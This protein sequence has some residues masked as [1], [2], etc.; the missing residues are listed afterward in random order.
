M[1]TVDRNRF[2]RLYLPI[3]M[4]NHLSVEQQTLYC[5]GA[6]VNEHELQE[7]D[8]HLSVCLAC[9][10][11]LFHAL[12]ENTGTLRR[13][14]LPARDESHCLDDATMTGYVRGQLDA[15]DREVVETHLSLCPRCA[16][17]VAS[18]QSFHEQM[19]R[20]DWTTLPPETLRERLRRLFH[21]RDF[22][23]WPTFRQVHT[24]WEH[25]TLTGR[26]ITALVVG[27]VLGW[28]LGNRATILN[29]VSD[30]ILRLLG[31]LATPLIF[32][33]IIHAFLKANVNAATARKL[34]VLLLTNT[35]VAIG[36]GLI[37]VNVFKP[38]R[39]VTAEGANQIADVAS[40]RSLAHKMPVSILAAVAE[41]NIVYVILAAVGIGIALRSVRTEQQRAGRSNFKSV[42]DLAE[43]TLLT[44]TKMIQW[45]IALVPF[46][47]CAI[48]AN[49]VG[50]KDFETV[51]SLGGFVA[52]VLFALAIQALYY[53]VRLRLGSWVTPAHF[54]RGGRSA[55]LTA[56]WTASSAATMP[57]TYRCMRERIGLKDESTSLGILVGGSL[58]R[59][60]TALYQTM[61]TLF[62]AQLTGVPFAFPRQLTVMLTSVMA[63]VGAPG[64]PEAGM[65]TML[66][67][68]RSLGLR[69]EYIGL[70][71]AV[72]WF[73]DRCRTAVNVMGHTSATCI[74][75]GKERP[76]G[77][78]QSV[79]VGP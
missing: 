34:V 7:I 44:L 73:L 72:D 38:G 33:A 70:L 58:N 1:P 48:I 20:F 23:P 50:R 25:Y 53:L 46:A 45:V 59:D 75:E 37:V 54:L 66:M 64:I 63:S 77:T 5:T 24:W 78:L 27:L 79:P 29:P 31:A 42:E 67:I 56:F 9:R 60:G 52:T 12:R 2:W 19:L 15:V 47:V 30:I 16:E 41:N 69:E 68:F 13:S 62:V 74:L 6:I 32:V 14:L 17:D 11:A 39:H 36:V 18:L 3:T 61:A 55:F 4:V 71:L 43:V 57:V 49:L 28:A 40:L 21:F 51:R 10:D 65:V 26:I 35:L 22:G 8:A 76:L